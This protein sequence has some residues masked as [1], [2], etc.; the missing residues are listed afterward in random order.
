MKIALI[1]TGGTIAGVQT[2]DKQSY[3]AGVLPAES[4]LAALPNLGIEVE[5]VQLAN[6]D[7]CDIDATLWFALA[8]TIDSL[9]ATADGIVITHGTDTLT[10][11]AFLLQ[12]LCTTPKPI[13]LTGAMRP[14]DALGAD[15]LRNLSN[16]FCIAS[17]ASAHK[18]GVLVT[19]S[20]TIFS[21][22]DCTKCA[23]FGTNA[24]IA[25]HGVLGYVQQQAVRFVCQ[26]TQ[27]TPHFSTREV[28]AFARVE[29]LL[30]YGH[31]GLFSA[32]DALLQ[33]GMR[34]VVVA[35]SG[36]G[37]IH[38]ALKQGLQKAAQQGLVVVRASQV[39]HSFVAADS[40]DS[41]FISA[42]SLCPTNARILLALLLGSGAN[43]Q[44]IAQTFALF[45]I[46]SKV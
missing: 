9:L 28:G 3:T 19:M 43:Y 14:S 17:S 31:N 24:F 27:P 39:A 21:A 23:S 8:R 13:V 15:G 2:P 40:E 32:L 35:G 4:L 18:R 16:A 41:D 10:E 46:D 22:S 44:T 1:A 20:D 12:L 30:S 42:G 45:G 34:G 33:S 25:Q 29:I 26:I 38:H 11:T 6:I 5:V 37:S 7:S 36:A